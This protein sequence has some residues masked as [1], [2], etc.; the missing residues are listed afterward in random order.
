MPSVFLSTE[1]EVAHQDRDGSR[2]ERGHDKGE[3][4][5]AE[6]IINLGAEQTIEQKEK[7]Q[8]PSAERWDT[9]K[10]RRWPRTQVPHRR[11]DLSRDL[12]HADRVGETTGAD[13]HIRSDQRQGNV[14]QE[15]ERYEGEHRPKWHGARRVR[16]DQ[17]EVEKAA[18]AT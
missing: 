7:F 6:R 5:E 18:C 15:P 14:D 16:A 9:C 3:R 13:A 2:R 10:E 17:K 11:R 12:V 1:V 4:Q 8:E